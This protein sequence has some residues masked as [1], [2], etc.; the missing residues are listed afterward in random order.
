LLFLNHPTRKTGLFNY[1][2]G[3]LITS[4]LLTGSH[5]EST[6]AAQHENNEFPILFT[7]QQMH[8]SLNLEKFKIYI[9]IHINIAPTCFGL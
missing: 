5:S 8:F 7:H 4:L 6:L 3:F 9:N 1:R 2:S